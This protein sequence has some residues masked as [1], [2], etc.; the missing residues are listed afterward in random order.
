MQVTLETGRK[1]Q[2]RVQL[3][4]GGHPIVYDMRYGTGK[5][6]ENIALWG[7]KLTLTHPTL[8]TPMTFTSLPRGSAFEP[9]RQTMIQ[10]INQEEN[11]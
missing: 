7:A 5:R 1:H 8:K 10:W 6:G 3:S 4:H 9:Y 11:Q 2:I